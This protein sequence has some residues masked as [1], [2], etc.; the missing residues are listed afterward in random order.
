MSPILLLGASLL[1]ATSGAPAVLFR[2]TPATAQRLATAMLLGGA[3]V[4]LLG[5]A[6]ALTGAPQTWTAPWPTP[7]ASLSVRVDAL[8]ALFLVPILA[9]PALGSVYGLCSRRRACSSGSP[10]PS[11]CL[12]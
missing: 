1:A 7:R 12:R 11:R 9:L 2:R 10:R 5:A 6:L 3:A 4:G 8:A